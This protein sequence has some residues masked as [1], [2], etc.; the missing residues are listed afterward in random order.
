MSRASR[1]YL[2]AVIFGAGATLLVM[3]WQTLNQRPA[4][5]L[6]GLLLL[7][8]IGILA[9]AL[10]FSYQV[11]QASASSSVTFIP[12]LAAV[13]L[14]PAPAPTVAAL[15]IGLVTE[16]S[17][18][19]K[20]AWKVAFNV[21]QAILATAA[22]SGVYALLQSH[23]AI[24]GM[25]G[26][27]AAAFVLFACN[28]L[29]MGG[30]I[31]VLQGKKFFSTMA[32]LVSGSG[33]SILFDMMV[34]P[35]AL[36]VAM[37][38][39][40]YGSAG[41]LVIALPL[42]L[43]R[44]A[45]LDKLQ[46]QRANR[47]LLRVLIKAIETRDPYTSG[48][49]VRVSLLSRTVA[50][51]LGLSRSKIDLVET[52][53]L[54]HDIGKIDGIYANLISKPHSLSSEERSIIRTHATKGADFLQGLS[55]FGDELVQGVRHHHERFD[56]GG[57]PDG[58]VGVSIPLAARI[59]MLCDSV[60]AM[61]S[62]RPYRKALPVS[63]VEAEL[64]RCAGAQFDPEIV[65]TMLA[66]GTLQRAAQLVVHHA[67]LAVSSDVDLNFPRRPRSVVAS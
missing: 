31:A 16:V 25:A 29:V 65:A 15:S 3:P 22:A 63:H 23:G 8:I 27:L 38:F 66:K 20:A 24:L 61:L 10:S 47:D 30:F 57:Y 26:F 48:H 36:V 40:N 46:V 19:S 11:G 35:I 52:A 42:L 51:D 45:Y 64:R 13:A 62:D 60:D 44:H 21:S 2:I 18:H 56:G 12:M 7:V 58:L 41:V 59:I 43:V 6:L 50:E 33:S 49:S 32:Q 5:D 34:S 54:L 55:S 37:F 4:Q 39:Q 67:P 14:F 9:E 53:A 28:Q 1:V 17:L